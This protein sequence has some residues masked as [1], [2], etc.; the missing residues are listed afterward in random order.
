[1]K[2]QCS[3]LLPIDIKCLIYV[4]LKYISRIVLTYAR[5]LQLT[6]NLRELLWRL[7]REECIWDACICFSPNVE[8]P[9]T[10]HSISD[11]V[12]QH[13]LPWPECG[14]QGRRTTASLLTNAWHGNRMQRFWKNRAFSQWYRKWLIIQRSTE[15]CVCVCSWCE[16]LWSLPLSL[17][18][19]P[20][21]RV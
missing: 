17:Q 15:V 9:K 14:V 6:A 3:I 2:P 12:C 20:L 21:C 19:W 8:T 4:K 5:P 11:A 18:P 16:L 13:L 10:S 1:M 7:K